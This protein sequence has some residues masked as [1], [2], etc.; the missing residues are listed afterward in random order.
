SLEGRMRAATRLTEDLAELAGMASAVAEVAVL[1]K[2]GQ[3]RS[4]AGLLLSAVTVRVNK[5]YKGA[6]LPGAEVT[7]EWV[8]GGDGERNIISFGQPQLN[9]GDITILL[10]TRFPADN[11]NWRVLG[12][13]VGQISVFINALGQ[14]VAKRA[15]GRFG[16]RVRGR[17]S[18][19]GAHLVTNEVLRVEQMDELL[20]SIVRTGQAVLE[21]ETSPAAVLP[22]PAAAAAAPT[23]APPGAAIAQPT[24]PALLPRILV[25]FVFIALLWLVSRGMRRHL[26]TNVPRAPRP[27]SFVGNRPV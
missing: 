18:T 19:S 12:G 27:H 3:V 7:V 21:H 2:A 26:P 10:L 11:P 6:L 14:C 16:Y 15:A 13:D 20:R 1:R 5:V 23:L 9:P 8:G 4:A 17:T 25:A 22:S 24:G